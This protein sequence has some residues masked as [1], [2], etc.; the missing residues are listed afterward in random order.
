M[1]L[2]KTNNLMA[3]D[4]TNINIFVSTFSDAAQ[5]LAG[6]SPFC[7][8]D[9][10]NAYHRLQMADQRSVELLALNF[11]SIIFAYK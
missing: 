10:F 1:D 8:T 6:M 3:E 2:K 11:A 7:K 4:Y 5:L 9:R